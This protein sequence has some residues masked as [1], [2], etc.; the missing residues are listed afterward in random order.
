MRRP[1]LGVRRALAMAGAFLAVLILASI[2]GHRS[3]PPASH[4]S[5]AGSPP[6]GR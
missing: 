4:G 3:P 5:T 6:A 1:S 2:V